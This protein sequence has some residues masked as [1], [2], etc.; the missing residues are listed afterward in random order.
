MDEAEKRINAQN[1]QH[2]ISWNP[3]STYFN[4]DNTKLKAKKR[5]EDRIKNGSS[6]K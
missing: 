1:E 3:F 5:M 2:D 6:C 4:R